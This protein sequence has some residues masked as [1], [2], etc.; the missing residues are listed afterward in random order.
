MSHLFTVEN[1]VAIP[2]TETL[3]ISPFKEVW[4]RDKSKDKGQAIKEFTF[5]ELMSSK[6]KA[7]PFG[8]L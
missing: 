6:K 3:L 2:N 8:L 4:E 1:N 5:V 7:N